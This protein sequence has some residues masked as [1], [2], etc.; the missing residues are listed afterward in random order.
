VNEPATR[1]AAVA[2]RP[3]S[4]Y[5]VPG[6]RIARLANDL[7]RSGEEG[8]LLPADVLGDLVRAEVTRVGSGAAQYTLTFNNWYLSTAKDRTHPEDA[9]TRLG[10]REPVEGANGLPAWPRFK[11]NDFALLRFGDRLRV[12]MRY[13]PESTARPASPDE[14]AQGWVPMVAGP[15]TDMR[16][17]FATAQGAQVTVSG[18]D[19]LSRLKD[20]VERLVKMG[21][22]PEVAIVKR[23]L[24]TAR[25]VLPLAKPLV[26][27][28]SFVTDENQGIHESLQAGQS[29]YDL[30]QK[31]ATRLDFEVFLEFQDV[32]S[33]RSALQFH[34][35]P[36]RG[37]ARPLAAGLFRLERERN[38]LEFNP[39]IKVVDQYSKVEVKGRHRDPLL[40]H[41]VVG[42]G[43]HTFVQEELHVDPALDQPLTTGPELRGVF[44]PGRPNPFQVA[45]QSN[46]DQVRADWNAISVI[47]RK[48]RELFTIE[49]TTV[50]TPE[51]RPGKFVE[52]RGM[53]PPF[54]GFYYVTK[55]VHTFGTDGYRTKVTA[56]RPGMPPP[57]RRSAGLESI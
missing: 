7:Q 29:P 47:R 37:R 20:K 11:Y 34:F 57:A 41:E 39:T 23:T 45:N 18:E 19:D 32:R 5:Y 14:K 24:E 21:P 26:D 30:I 22:R 12:D 17:S 6:A 3:G 36:Y 46:L 42:T 52:I 38:L 10:A 55:T 27:Y 44:Y 53:R 9:F 28:P 54:D 8:T 56:S 50:G 16:F 35:E 1:S 15:V 13:V 2:D 48:A 4:S 31:L 25:F 43:T 49:A 33:P 40:A 51:L